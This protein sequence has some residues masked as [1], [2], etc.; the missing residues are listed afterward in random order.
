MRMV[1]VP[2]KLFSEM[3]TPIIVFMMALFQATESVTLEDLENFLN[4]KEK[5]WTRYRSMDLGSKEHKL[6]CIYADVR[7]QGGRHYLY[8]QHYEVQGQWHSQMFH[9][10]A[11]QSPRM[12]PVL[13]IK[14]RDEK[15]MCEMQN[16]D[17]HVWRHVPSC[18]MAYQKYCPGK[19]F[20]IYTRQ[21][22]PPQQQE[23]DSKVTFTK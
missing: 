13:R 11:R 16:W 14:S 3:L 9:A 19:Q 7:R 20:P 6:R 2:Q 10:R 21:C 5:I 15:S 8:A 22:S 4:T 1:H 12:H 17:D 23:F 18:Q